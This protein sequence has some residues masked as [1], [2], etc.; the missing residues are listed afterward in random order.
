MNTRMTVRAAIVVTGLVAVLPALWAHHSFSAS[1]KGVK[2]V[3]LVGVVTKVEWANPHMYFY[4]LVGNSEGKL[5]SWIW[6]GGLNALARRGWT[7]DLLKA[8]DTVKVIAYR[9]R[10]GDPVASAREVVL[11]GGRKKVGSSS[12]D[13][14]PVP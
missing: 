12:Y 7:R 6:A 1:F 3:T 11:N 8:G 9:A 13:G 14:G 4:M 5:V 2:P 10:G